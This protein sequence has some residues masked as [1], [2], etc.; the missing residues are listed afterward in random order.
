MVIVQFGL[1]SGRYSC[2]VCWSSDGV[3][4]VGFCLLVG[5]FV[6]I[7][8]FLCMCPILLGWSGLCVG[9]LF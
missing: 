9:V 8:C 5:L 4:V 2:M 1:V 3:I 7:L 6:L